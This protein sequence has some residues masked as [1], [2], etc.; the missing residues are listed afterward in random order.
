MIDL[1]FRE[2]HF[3]YVFIDEAS[4]A[5]EPLMLIPFALINKKSNDEEGTGF[6][7]QIVI[8]GD[9][10]QLGPVVRCK[11]IEHLLGK[12]FQTGI[13]YHVICIL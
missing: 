4:Q 12:L 11:R 8:A 1:N 7:A 9:P 3:S 5:T 6:Q 10:Y 2:D 13:K